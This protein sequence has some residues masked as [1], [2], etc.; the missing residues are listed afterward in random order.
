MLRSR[1]YVQEPILSV[2]ESREGQGQCLY[3]PAGEV[4]L[5]EG[6][7]PS[8]SAFLEVN[9]AS[10]TVKIFQRDLEERAQLVTGYSV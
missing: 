2:Q 5:V 9:W 10:R 3:V 1:Y 8:N 7:D 6:P 4:I